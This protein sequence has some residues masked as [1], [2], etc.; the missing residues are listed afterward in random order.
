MVPSLKYPLGASCGVV[1]FLEVKLGDGLERHCSLTSSF[2]PRLHLLVTVYCSVI[3]QK[4]FVVLKEAQLAD[5][6]TTIEIAFS[7]YF[8]VCLPCYSLLS[9]SHSHPLLR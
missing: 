7:D 9:P 3:V 1:S 5:H 4:Y 6:L 2:A 8:Y